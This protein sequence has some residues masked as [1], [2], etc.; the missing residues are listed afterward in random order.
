MHFEKARGLSGTNAV[1]AF[2]AKLE[3]RGGAAIWTMRGIE[4][5]R[6]TEILEMKGEGMSVRKI[7]A[8]LG[9]TKSSVQRAIDKRGKSG[10]EAK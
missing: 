1:S 7:A 8:E 3:M 9:M 10:A 6:L 2:E 5:A 4:D